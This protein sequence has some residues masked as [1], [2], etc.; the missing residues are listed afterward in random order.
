MCIFIHLVDMYFS[1]DE[2]MPHLRR[3]PDDQDRREREEEHIRNVH[4]RDIRRDN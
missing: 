4:I 1:L 3:Y 2:K